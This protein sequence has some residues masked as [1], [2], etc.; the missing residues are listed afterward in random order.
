MPYNS[1]AD[2]FHIKKIFGRI[3]SRKRHFLRENVNFA[4]FM[5]VPFEGLMT[6][7][8]FQLRLTGKCV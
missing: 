5:I 6:S 2:S 3:S 1:V 4:F 8:A 7:H